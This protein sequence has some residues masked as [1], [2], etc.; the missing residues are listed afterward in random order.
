MK[1]SL[2]ALAAVLLLV[3]TAAIADEHLVSPQ[4]AQQRLLD[5][6]AQR[7]RNIATLDAFV[8]SPEGSAAIAAVGLEPSR[9][10]GSLVKLSDTELK[11]LAARASALQADPVAG[12]PF[13][14]RQIVWIAAIALAVVLLVIL[15]S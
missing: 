5:T 8:A 6:A 10:H 11:D 12:R 7:E 9:V 14:N 13:S 3:S 4:A 2:G 1:K 15:I